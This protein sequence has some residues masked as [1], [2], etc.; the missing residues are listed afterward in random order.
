M[1]PDWFTFWCRGSLGHIDGEAS[2]IA[3]QYDNSSH[4][5]WVRPKE[6]LI[7]IDPSLFVWLVLFG[8]HF[9]R[10]PL[11]YYPTVVRWV[12]CIW[13]S[14]SSAATP[15]AFSALEDASS[16]GTSGLPRRQILLMSPDN[17]GDVRVGA[18]SSTLRV[19][20]SKS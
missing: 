14:G 2:F 18:M 17:R 9:A 1:V 10:L 3:I 4:V 20:R 16:L 7:K 19:Q 11:G 6:G 8:F 5:L 12:W 15:Q 13:P